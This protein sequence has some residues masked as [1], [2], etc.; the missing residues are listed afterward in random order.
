MNYLK[1][2]QT[3]FLQ[4]VLCQTAYFTISTI[5][6]LAVSALFVTGLLDQKVLILK[7]FLFTVAFL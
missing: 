4:S 5:L 1:G 3:P 6:K 2:L 7:L